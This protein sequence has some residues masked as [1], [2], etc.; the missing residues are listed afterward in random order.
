MGEMLRDDDRGVGRGQIL[1]GT[2]YSKKESLN[3]ILTQQRASK[4]F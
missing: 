1:Q 2:S 3:L 4:R